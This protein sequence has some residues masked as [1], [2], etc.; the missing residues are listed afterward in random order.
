MRP[1]SISFFCLLLTLISSISFCAD[2]YVRQGVGDDN[3][4]GTYS[5]PFE[6]IDGAFWYLEAGDTLY[7]GDGTYYEGEFYPDYN[8]SPSNPITIRNIPDEKPVCD[9]Q[10]VYWQ[11]LGLVEKDG[12]V[13]EG[14]TM[15][16][17]KSAGISCTKTGYV[18]VRDCVCYANGSGGIELN[19]ADY[20]HASYNAHMTVEDCV[21]YENGWQDGWSSGIHINNKSE[22]GAGSHHII[23]RNICYNNFDGSGYHTDGNGIM[24]DMG[25]G[26]SALIENN[27]CFNNGGAGVRV[28]D[29]D[30]TVI[31][32]TCFRNGWDPYN[33]Y[34]PCEIELIERHIAGACEGCVV[35]NNIC[36]ARPQSMQGG[37]MYGGVFTA[38]DVPLSDFVFDHNNLWSDVP[39]EVT[40]ESWMTDCTKAMPLIRHYAT[41]NNTIS[42]YGTI[43]LDMDFGD[44]DFH[45]V[46][47]SPAIDAG[48][49]GLAPDHDIEMI[50][51]P[52]GDGFDAGCYEYFQIQ[53]RDII[54]LAD[55]ETVE[56]SDLVV[57]HVG[58]DYF[59]MEND[60]RTG[61]VRTDMAGLAVNVGDRVHVHGTVGTDSDYMRYIQA[62]SVSVVGSGLVLPF[63]MN[64]SS[65]GG[66]DFEYDPVTGAGQKGVTGG[67]GLTNMGL[68]V[69]T[70][71]EF[72]YVDANT[73]IV[74][75]GST[76]GVKC[77]VLPGVTLDPGWS[78][79]SLTGVSAC[80]YDGVNVNRVVLVQ[81]QSDIVSE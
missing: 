68:L 41:D 16:N 55:G 71:G 27:L 33:P 1:V 23:R 34:Q 20:P 5:E 49:P 73:F 29:G 64:N 79:V 44:Y 6:T 42:K 65:V 56:A 51:R 72:T 13:V 38:E 75:D 26:G 21:C 7:I 11:F 46:Y 32:N 66:G 37:Q 30:A 10:G 40:V 22:G 28:M 31:N 18:T 48:S 63:Y 54:A 69:R 17:Y 61:G 53:A 39:A 52:L 3:N 9:G 78:F 43:F 8:A 14:L 45:Q 77:V 47:G 80:E 76:G 25:G 59:F 81:T 12:F 58:A 67:V 36:W 24:F 50:A 60:S 70:A 62:D 4:P 15:R 57:T 19:Y 35:R 2:Y 74:D